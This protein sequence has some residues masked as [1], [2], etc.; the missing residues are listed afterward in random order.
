MLDTSLAEKEVP[1]E[2]S[3]ILE[4]LESGKSSQTYPVRDLLRW[5]DSQRRGIWVVENI[6]AT[7]AKLNVETEPDFNEVPID[8]LV[9]F[10]IPSTVKTTPSR[11]QNQTAES[12]PSKE[13][14]EQEESR[15]LKIGQFAEANKQIISVKPDTPLKEITTLMMSYNVCQVPVMQTER[16]VKG[17]VSWQSIG[18]SLSL[19]GSCERAQDCM[20]E[21]HEIPADSSLFIATERVNAHGY[22]L[23]RSR[24]KSIAGIVTTEDIS[25]ILAYLTEP[26]LLVGEIENQIRLLLQILPLQELQQVVD[27]REGSK[28]ITDVNQLS[29]G[30]YIKLLENP[31]TFEKIQIPVDRKIL[32]K[33]LD[34]VREIRNQVMHF[35]PDDPVSENEEKQ[36]TLRDIASFLRMLRKMVRG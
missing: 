16:E 14:T 22:V 8:S 1:T 28:E 34:Q 3:R 24:N 15:A 20:F 35:S 2:L 36:K 19:N 31:V 33:R 29:F 23:L 17:M 5:F 27:Q 30:D 7:L 12:K 11:E 25:K 32:I 6:R 13:E 9:S 4:Q 18:V 21:H 26:F 10:K